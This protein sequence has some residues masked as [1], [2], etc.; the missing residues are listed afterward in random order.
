[1]SVESGTEAN[2]DEDARVGDAPPPVRPI[3]ARLGA[4]GAAA[5]ASVPGL[6]AW[7]VTVAPAAWSRNGS[8]VA[9]LA[10]L[11]GL[12]AIAVGVAMES[13]WGARARY[14]S[15]WGLTLTSAIVWV[16]VP[17][18]L[19]PLRLDAPRGVAGMIGWGLF[20][21]ASAAPALGVDAAPSGRIVDDAPLRPR[22][23]IRR[24]DVIYIGGAI[25]MGLALQVIGWRVSVPERALLIRLVTLAAGLSIVGAATTV[26]LA[27]HARS[28]VPTTRVRLRA[29][30]P[31]IVFL[32][33]LA[34]GGTLTWSR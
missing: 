30:L 31:W 22:A 27:R 34:A 14:V 11:A 24:G 8:M 16:L 7:A 3:F 23:P 29:A 32:A 10:S 2:E 19:G 21:L 17:A 9:R 25:V 1:M 5:Q 18:A 6:Y 4:I 12:G 28:H 15:V 26:S 33:M 13:R 20:A